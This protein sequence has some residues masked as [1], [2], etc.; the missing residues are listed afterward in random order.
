MKMM[1]GLFSDF[2]D[3]FAVKAGHL[4]QLDAKLVEQKELIA[5]IKKAA[6]SEK[7]R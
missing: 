2:L 7:A 5:A 1:V 4:D 3:I 6:T